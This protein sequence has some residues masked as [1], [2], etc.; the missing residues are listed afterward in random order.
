ME[1]VD[2]PLSPPAIEAR[3]QQVIEQIIPSGDRVEHA[4]DTF[5]RLVQIGQLCFL[6]GSTTIQPP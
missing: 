5:W 4:G 3:A 6:K 2:G 1:R